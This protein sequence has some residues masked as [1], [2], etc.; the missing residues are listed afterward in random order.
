MYEG[1]FSINVQQSATMAKYKCTVCG[2]I[3]DEARE[4]VAFSELPEDWKCPLCRSPKSAFELM[5]ED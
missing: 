1:N 2:E 5:E 4:K 3:Y